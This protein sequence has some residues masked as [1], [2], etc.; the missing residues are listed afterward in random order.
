MINKYSTTIIALL[1][2]LCIGKKLPDYLS[3][4]LIHHHTEEFAED[5][6]FIPSGPLFQKYIENNCKIDSLIVERVYFNTY[7]EIVNEELKI[8]HFD[9]A[10]LN[11]RLQSKKFDTTKRKYGYN[12]FV[13]LDKEFF[14]KD[15]YSFTSS[16]MTANNHKIYLREAYGASR[17]VEIYNI[18]SQEGGKLPQDDRHPFTTKVDSSYKLEID[19]LQWKIKPT[20]PEKVD[21]K[22]Y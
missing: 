11:I 1:F 8:L 3:H 21:W 13:L 18:K 17:I 2:P 14:V 10:T 16:V 7:N 20:L 6:F 9:Y 15:I 19:T 22:P 12:I 4:V 5:E